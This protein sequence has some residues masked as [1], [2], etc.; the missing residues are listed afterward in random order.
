MEHVCSFLIVC[1]G[2][3][4][5][6]RGKDGTYSYGYGRHEYLYVFTLHLSIIIVYISHK[7][8]L[9]VDIVLSPV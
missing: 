4:L 3:V 2:N 8:F 5:D 1:I 7:L 9:Y 6:K